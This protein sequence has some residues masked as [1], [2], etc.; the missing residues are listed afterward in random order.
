MSGKAWILGVCVWWI[1]V[2]SLQAAVNAAGAAAATSASEKN[3]STSPSVDSAPEWKRSNPDV[4]IYLPKGETYHD[5]DNE[6]FLVFP[7]PS[8]KE[9]LAT[10][11][12]SS[13][14]GRGDNRVMIA[15]SKDGQNWS[16]PAMIA[17]S[18]PGS[19]GGQ[20]SWGF[21][22]VSRKGRFYLF[23]TRQTELTDGNPQGC[24]MMGCA[25]S[26][27]EGKSWTPAADI[28]M[29]RNEFDNPDPKVPKNWIVWQLPIRDAKGRPF[30]GYTQCTSLSRMGPKK[31]PWYAWSGRCQFMRFENI[32]EGP[33]PKDLRITWLPRD[34]KG[35]EVPHPNY[36]WSSCSEPAPV[37]LPDGR[38]FTTMRTWT[39][40]IWYSVS[41]D[42]GEAWR[43]TEVLRYKD[44]GEPVQHPLAPCPIY[45]LRDGRFLL[46][47]HNNDGHVGPYNQREKAWKRNNLNFL[48]H[49]AFLAVGEYRPGAHQPIWFSRPKQILDTQ[50]VSIGPK[51]SSEIATYTSLTEWGGSRILWYP[52]RKYFLL[53]K[54]ITDEWLADLRVP[55]R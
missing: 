53:G 17:G 50:G 13:C 18:P 24:G 34:P 26:D 27:D 40:Q 55:E 22:I 33:D 30:V 39:G 7:S 52:D 28:P 9:L 37:L 49:P 51:G 44:G 11:T 41:D 35:L 32:D 48:R 29:P 4:V 14:E 38:L 5:T 20:A 8:G 23:Y 2:L 19:K 47:F 25:Y 10:W 31:P 15:R 3:A 1:A 6:H 42:N 54:R 21:C 16:A 12:Q 46:L 43:P 45:A 36:D